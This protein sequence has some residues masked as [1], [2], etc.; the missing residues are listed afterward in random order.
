MKMGVHVIVD[1]PEKLQ[2]T[3]KNFLVYVHEMIKLA[4]IELF[5]I[6]K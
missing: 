6:L 3:V 4:V 1:D 2:G 5:F